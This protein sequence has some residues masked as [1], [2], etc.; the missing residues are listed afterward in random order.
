MKRKNKG[1]TLDS[2]LREDGIYEDVTSAA[3]KRVLTRQLEA[4]MRQKSISRAEMA[5]QMHTSRAALNRL[6][7]P[8]NESVT[9]A[10][11]QKA[12]LVVGRAIRLELV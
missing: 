5:R 7:D 3:I 1:S 6:L 9:L 11:L 10:T 2:L 8:A 12:A 4:A